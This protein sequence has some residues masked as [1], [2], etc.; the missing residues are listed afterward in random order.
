[1]GIPWKDTD[2]EPLPPIRFC[3]VIEMAT[4]NGARALGLGDVTGSLTPGKRADLIL[5][6]TNDLNIAPLA[7]LETTVV[8]SASPENVN[9]VMVD[10]IFVKRHGRLLGFDVPTIV[11]RAKDFGLAHQKS[12]GRCANA[13]FGGA[14][15]SCFQVGL[16]GSA[17]RVV[18]LLL[19]ALGAVIRSVAHWPIVFQSGLSHLSS[20]SS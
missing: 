12:G 16:L 13:G 10:G 3:E 9:S 4:I 14:R 5:L 20:V 1:M 6:R 18:G 19:N 7:N 15:K 8:Q 11:G 2:T 17:V